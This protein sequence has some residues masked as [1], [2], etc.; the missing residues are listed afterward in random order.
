MCSDFSSSLGGMGGIPT[1]INEEALA[2]GNN[3]DDDVVG[4]TDVD[5]TPLEGNTE[6]KL[7]WQ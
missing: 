7:K 5:S 6:F 2:W 4:R 1:S 3:D